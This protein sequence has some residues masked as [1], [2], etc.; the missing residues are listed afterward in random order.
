[1]ALIIL[2]INIGILMEKY[3]GEKHWYINDK[4]IK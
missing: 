3:N 4:F 2:E 1:M